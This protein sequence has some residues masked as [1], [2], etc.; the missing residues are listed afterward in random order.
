MKLYDYLH[1][2]S[3]NDY[4]GQHT[5]PDKESGSPLYDLTLNGTYPNDIYSSKAKEYYGTGSSYDSI[6][7]NII[8]SYKDKP[9][10]SI[11]IYRALPDL[12]KQVNK[13]IKD[14]TYLFSYKDKYSFFPMSLNKGKIVHPILYSL[15]DKYSYEDYEYDERQNLIIKD[16]E[17]QIIK[18]RSQLKKPLKINK[19]DWV[20]I[21]RQYA[22]DHGDSA[23][24]DYKIISKKVQAKNIYTNGD[25]IHEWGYDP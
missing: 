19:G 4:K 25:S 8:Q 21:T 9:N 16:L 6:T 22:K 2:L 11:T 14:I 20:S 17:N 7:I 5:A 10:K 23:L 1:L 24:D 18:L 13:Q 15:E 3:E 12:N